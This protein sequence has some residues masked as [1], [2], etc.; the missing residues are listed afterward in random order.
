VSLADL[1]LVVAGVSSVAGVVAGFALPRRSRVVAACVSTTVVGVAAAVAAV[2]V[3]ATGDHVRA[4]WRDVLPLGG[5]TVD[6]DPL[7]AW[8]VLAASV[9][10]V[11]AA[12]YAVGYCDHALAGR[13]VQGAFPLFAVTLVLVPAAASVS[14]FLVL[15]E[16]MAL[17]SLLLVAAEHRERPAVASAAVWY[18]VM[19]HLGF[20]AILIALGLAAAGTGGET[21]ASIRQ[22]A[23]ELSSSR[24]S[25]VFV[26]A[27]VGFGSKAGMVPLHVW[28]PRAHPEAPSHVSALM[29]GAMVKLGIYGIVRV[30]VDLLGGGP[31]WWGLLL[32]VIGIGSALFGI[33]H[34]LVASDLKVLLAYSTTEN[35]GL[36]VV[37]VGASLL[38]TAEHEHLLAGVALAAALLHVMNHALFKGLLFLGAGSVVRATGTRNLDLLGGLT[39]RMP[40]TGALFTVGAVAIAALPPLNGF[41]S[42]WALLQAL[43]RAGGRTPAVLG[44]TMPIAV[45]AVALTAGL[46]AATFVKAVGT[47][48]LA[49]PRSPGAERAVDPP[50]PMQAGMAL[51]ATGCIALGL[52]PWLLASSVGRAVRTAGASIDPLGDGVAELRLAGGSGVMS[53][54]LVAIS[55]VVGLVAVVAAMRVLGAARARRRAE[56]WG[57]GRVLQTAR[58][59]YTATSFAE[60]LQRVFDDVLHPELD[61]DVTH[62]AE[63]RWYVGAVRYRTAVVDGFDRRVYGPLIG[64][65][66]A[67]GERARAIQNGSVHRY[68]A[69]GFVALLVVLVVAR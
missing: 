9:V 48:F 54:V 51:L 25:I 67:Y 65:A 60:P 7:G 40:V 53:P 37:G 10:V 15:W 46:A 36:I 6:L 18:G 24:A 38:L 3:L 47:G 35:V 58:M 5:V 41:V 20:V 66:R 42:E 43:V 33:L 32:L 62:A 63:S 44:L 11:A 59:E 26:L 45:G 50:A 69:Y 4:H 34:A 17:T 49:L 64:L 13:S 27:V 29:S 56:N 8:F 16:L 12:V 57:C 52:L 31:R 1:A 30:G 39:R 14:T 2:R 21:F 28:L 19:T 22:G 55:L 61:V 23:S 68:L